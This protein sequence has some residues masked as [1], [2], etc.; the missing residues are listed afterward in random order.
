MKDLNGGLFST[1]KFFLQVPPAEQ[2]SD[3]AT[4]F[5][6]FPPRGSGLEK[7]LGNSDFFILPSF[8]QPVFFLAV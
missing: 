5:R 8:L 2:L 4:S 3:R 7:L 1:A 6:D